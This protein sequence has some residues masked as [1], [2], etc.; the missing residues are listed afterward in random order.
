M[1]PSWSFPATQ[2]GEVE[3][4][5]AMKALVCDGEVSFCDNYPVPI[6]RSGEVLVQVRRAGICNT[7]IEITK[8][9]MNY[10]GVLG[11]EFVGQ[12]ADGRRVVGEINVSDGTC[13]LCRRGDVTHCGNR[14]VLGILQRDGAMAE[15]LTLPGRNLHLV[16]D[17][18]TDAQAV[19]VEPLAAACEITDQVHIRPSQR[20]VILGDGKLGIL[21]A[22]VLQLTGCGLSV[23]GRHAR[24]LAILRKRG[25]ATLDTPA[26]GVRGFDVA[27]DC[28][29]QASGFELARQ[30]LRPRGTL[31]L[32]STFHGALALTI[33]PLVIDEISVIG[34]RCGPFAPALRFLEQRLIDVDTLLDAEYPMAQGV[35]AFKRAMTPGTLK[36]QIVMR[37]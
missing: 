25:I 11:H 10:R 33:A 7:D 23:V 14:S 13:D 3:G 36:V 22:Q 28:S 12:L 8:G 2:N 32:K 21:V 19:F 35:E 29:G 30:L 6:P 16:P 1:Q 5:S 20:V 37:N 24:K 26:D 27:I 18:V 15:Y 4:V 34:S 9:Y 17:T 31:V